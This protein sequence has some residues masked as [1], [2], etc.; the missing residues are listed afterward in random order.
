MADAVKIP[1]TVEEAHQQGYATERK[2]L[3]EAQAIMRAGATAGI[4]RDGPHR[5]C[6][7]LPPNHKCW[8][9]DCDP[10]GWKEVLFCDG[11]QGCTIYAKVRCR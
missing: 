5:D 10:S 4:L 8:E 11:T 1:Q 6:S 9:G 2:T 3:E 7:T